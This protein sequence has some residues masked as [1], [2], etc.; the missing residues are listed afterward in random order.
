ME[1]VFLYL[2]PIEEYNRMFL[3]SDDYYKSVGKRKPFDVLNE[4][5]EK[6]YRSKGYKV[7]FALYPDKTIYGIDKKENDK[8]IYTDVLFKEASG[9]NEDGTEK[10]K[11]E[12]KYPNENFLISQIGDVQSIVVGGFHWADCVRRVAEA[13]Y[14]SGIDTIIDLDLTD[15]FFGVYWREDYFKID[16]YD[17]QRYKN[18]ILKNFGIGDPD[19]ALNC[20]NNMYDSPIFGFDSDSS[21]KVL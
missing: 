12:I 19:F 21:K 6:R 10:A 8:I 11:S 2:Y 14:E 1:K 4:C 3:F 13:C 16:E 20:F 15:I 9:Y 17:P 5:I 7:I 18:Y